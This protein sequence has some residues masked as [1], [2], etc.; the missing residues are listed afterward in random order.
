MAEI[1]DEGTVAAWNVTKFYV[2]FFISLCVLGIK[3]TLREL[4]SM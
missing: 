4:R 2:Q 1:L 3:K